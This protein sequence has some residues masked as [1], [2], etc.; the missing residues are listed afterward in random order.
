MAGTL[1]ST[2]KQFNAGD[3]T[4]HI[5]TFSII[6][7]G[8]TFTSNINSVVSQWSNLTDDPTQE[9]EGADVTLTTAS[10]GLFTIHVGENARAGDLFVLSNS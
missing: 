9:K 4:L 7:D 1:L 5:F 3:L 2:T 8:G 6:D 10:S